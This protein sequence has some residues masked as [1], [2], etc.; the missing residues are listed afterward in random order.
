MWAPFASAVAVTGSFNEWGEQ[1]L[2]KKGDGIWSGRAENAKP[3]QE[4]KFVITN[5]ERK[6]Q[7]NDPRALQLT[8]SG[9]NS[10]IID[11]K[12]DWE[13]DNYE[14]PEINKRVVYELHIGTFNRHDPATPG[15]FETATEKLD[16]LA[17]L[18]INV[19]ELMPVTSTTADRW[20]G[21]DPDYLFAVEAAYGGRWAFMEFVKE[22]HKRGIGVILDVVYNHMSP[23]PGMDLWQF[24]GW[25]QDN[26]G[27]IY[28]YNDWRGDTPWGPR[29]DYGREEVRE[30]IVDNAMMW[31]NDC[32][33]D[34]LRLDAVFQIRNAYGRNDDP[35]SDLPDGWKLVQ[36]INKEAKKIKPAS[37]IVAED[38][39]LNEWITKPISEKGA[40]FDAQWATS[41]PSTLRSAIIPVDDK[42]RRIEPLKAAIEKKFNGGAFQRVVYS[43]S[44]DADANGHARTN[45]EIAPGNAGNLHARRRSTL[46]AG[47]MM[48]M[49]GV[50]M[51][52]QGQEF[53]E[54]GWF[55][56]WKGLDWTKTKEFPGIVQLY[57]DLIK[58]RKNV[59]GKTGG[60]YGESVEILHIHEDDK[61]IVYR[62]FGENDDV[63]V[64]ANLSH[65]QK[66]NYSVK[67]PG[68]GTWKVRF[69]S[70]WD[71]YSSDFS[72][73]ETP[74][75]IAEQS[76]GPLN[77]GPYSLVI[78]SK[79]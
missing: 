36:A 64:A 26:H 78:L 5:G 7:K 16:Y 29:L 44:H 27:G 35:G 49:P 4:Y 23:Y 15:T 46:A 37:M 21:Y 43:E 60:L 75:V 58:L 53:M 55:N 8:T 34:G 66:L 45:E 1:P 72:N 63:V 32:H 6:F 20:W 52:F 18:G 10:L 54:D 69:N 71:G 30:Y 38:M 61:V 24:D 28:F 19:I 40:G 25:S 13:D 76:K 56:H 22:A 59:E 14:L 42:D 2:E 12:F 62:R 41:M 68:D 3:G 51:L 31:L 48:T 77:L 11:P 47:L 17:D 65:D 33:V 9:D 57:K 74:D 67:F 73:T 39:D 50:P 70:D 79:D